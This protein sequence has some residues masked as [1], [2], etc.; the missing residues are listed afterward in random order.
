MALKEARERGQ[1]AIKNSSY[2]FS[3]N[4]SWTI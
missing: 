2:E 3:S 4:A 1:S